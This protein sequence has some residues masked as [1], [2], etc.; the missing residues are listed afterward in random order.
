[1]S[2]TAA[3]SAPLETNRR[4]KPPGLHEAKAPPAKGPSDL[5]RCALFAEIAGQYQVTSPRT[6][7]DTNTSKRDTVS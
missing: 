6:V 3:P 1:M 4:E 5:T 7:S 2:S